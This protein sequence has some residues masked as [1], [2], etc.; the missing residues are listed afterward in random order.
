M[1]LSVS[2]VGGGPRDGVTRNA[3]LKEIKHAITLA[4]LLSPSMLPLLEM[5]CVHM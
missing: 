2:S 4:V 5:T 3:M 1:G